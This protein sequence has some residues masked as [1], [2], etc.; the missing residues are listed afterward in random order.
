MLQSPLVKIAT[1]VF[2]TLGS[3]S[4]LMSSF[5]FKK[6]LGNSGQMQIITDTSRYEEI[7]NQLWSNHDEITH[8]PAQIPPDA[9]R[10]H[11]AYSPGFNQGD[12]FFQVR[13][14][15]PFSKIRQLLSYYGKISQHQYRGGDTNDHLNQPNG[16]PTTF[17]YTSDA[18]TESFP[19]TYEIMVLNAQDQGA[20]GFKWNHGDS[21]GVAINTSDSEIVYWVEKW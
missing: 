4:I 3:I 15:Q 2:C 8:F 20:S 7:R 13:F 14:K 11:L 19:P 5:L 21:Y 10:V 16:V 17:F 18:A 6:T 12:S 1:L 9:Q